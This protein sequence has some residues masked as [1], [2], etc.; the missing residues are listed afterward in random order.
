MLHATGELAI[1][2]LLLACGAHVHLDVGSHV[3]IGALSSFKHLHASGLLIDSPS[4]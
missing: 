2:R 3:S 1:P 4:K